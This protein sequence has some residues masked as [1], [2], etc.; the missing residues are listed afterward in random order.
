MPNGGPEITNM[1]LD[2]SMITHIIHIN[3]KM[4]S[5]LDQVNSKIGILE[6][7]VSTFFL[8]SS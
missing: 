4:K 3:D 1:K 2:Q 5:D 8:I 7:K 6:K